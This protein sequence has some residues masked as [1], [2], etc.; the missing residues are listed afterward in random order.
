M[1]SSIDRAHRDRISISFQHCIVTV[2][3]W[4]MQEFSQKK[5]PGASDSAPGKVVRL[6]DLMD[7]KTKQAR[8]RPVR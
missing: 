8:G 5:I 7:C 3:K 1:I 2:K 4:I 6:L